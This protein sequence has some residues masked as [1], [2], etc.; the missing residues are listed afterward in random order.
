[1]HKICF[2]VSLF[3]ASTCFEHHVL[4]VRRSKLYYTVS[5]I[6]TPVGGLWP[7]IVLY[8]DKGSRIVRNIRTHL[9]GY[10]VA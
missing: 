2:T 4:I 1:M 3:P 7:C 6:I 9:A 5:G 8:R 10:V